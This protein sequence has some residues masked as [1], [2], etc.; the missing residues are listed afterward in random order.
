MDKRERVE[1]V[2]SF[3]IP[4][5]VPLCDSFQHAGVIAHYAGISERNDWTTE[6]VCKAASNAVDMVQGWGL[7][8]SFIKGQISIDRHGIKWQTDTWFSQIIERPFKTADDYA[9]V[10][11]KEIGRMRKTCP[12]YPDTTQK[13]FL[14]DDLLMCRVKDFHHVFL[15]YQ[16]M[17]GDTVLMYPDVSPGLDSLYYLGGWE[18]LT[19]L[20]IE[21][22]DL[23]AEYM[24]AQTVLQVERA[25]AIADERLSPV[26]LIACDIAHKEGLLI[27]P[28]FLKKEYFPRVKRITEAYHEHGLKVFYHSEGNLWQILDEL[29]IGC[30]IDGMNPLEPH[31]HMDAKNVRAKYPGLVLWGGVDNS[32]LL[33][34]GTPAQVRSRVE[35]LIELGR[36]GGMLIG[37]TGQIH[38]AC[39]KENVITMIETVK[40]YKRC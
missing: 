8:P 22:P 40:G 36:Q 21:H 17:L 34:R 5:R 35:E 14:D 28:D 27:S 29:V 23:L 13:M 39:K 2:L 11:K 20:L 30:G 9:C 32:Y 31:S 26:V 10:L 4:D 7:G 1:H 24:E 16:K 19:D 38:P 37:T 18:L 3:E 12:D 25:H 15:Q 33:V 6:E